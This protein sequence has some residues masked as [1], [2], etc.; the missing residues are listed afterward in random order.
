MTDEEYLNLFKKIKNDDENLNKTNQNEMENL[1]EVNQ[2]K[3][4]ID[5]DPWQNL[6]NL[7]ETPVSKYNMNENLNDGWGTQDFVIEKIM[8]G[9]VITNNDPYQTKKIKQKTE[10]LNGL[11]QFVDDEPLKS[12]NEVYQTNQGLE[13]PTINEKLSD[14]DIVSVELFE[15]MHTNA[16]ITL[17]NHPKFK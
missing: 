1:N 12:V 13:P 7:N 6:Q 14:I 15:R 4:N 9:Q 10:N 2:N 11:D 5:P 3:I 8:N 17:K 16:M